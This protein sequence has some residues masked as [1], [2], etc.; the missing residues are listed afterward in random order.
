MRQA[1]PPARLGRENHRNRREAAPRVGPNSMQIV[2]QDFVQINKKAFWAEE[3]EFQFTS[4]SDRATSAV[5]NMSTCP[6]RRRVGQP[7]G[8]SHA[9]R[10]PTIPHRRVTS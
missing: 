10:L 6:T 8:D 3:S 1:W 7:F 5:T 4:Q 9:F 2:G